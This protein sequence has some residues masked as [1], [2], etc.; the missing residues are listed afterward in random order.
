M[1]SLLQPSSEDKDILLRVDGEQPR[2]MWIKKIT[3][4]SLDFITTKKKMER[5][6]KEKCEFVRDGEVW[7]SMEL[8]IPAC[9][10]TGFIGLLG[11][12]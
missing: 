5:E 3:K 2:D 6:K 8:Y 12:S 7:R 11:N 4:A 1:L 10:G 9:G